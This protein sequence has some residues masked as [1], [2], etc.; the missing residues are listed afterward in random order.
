[1]EGKLRALRLKKAQLFEQ[2]GMLAEIS[3]DMYKQF[4]KLESD[5]MFLEKQILRETKNDLDEN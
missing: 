4:G 2:M 5:I 3:G 1:M